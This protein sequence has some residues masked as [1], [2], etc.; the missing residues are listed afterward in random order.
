[1]M[2]RR[3]D[4]SITAFTMRRLTC[5]IVCT[6]LKELAREFDANPDDPW[7]GSMLGD[8]FRERAKNHPLFND[9]Q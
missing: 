2:Q 8:F 6:E 3:E 7:T 4:E 1:M 5:E 9:I